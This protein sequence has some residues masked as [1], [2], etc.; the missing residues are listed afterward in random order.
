VY[1]TY[2]RTQ[3]YFT[4]QYSRNT[5]TCFGLLCGPSSGCA[6][7]Y[8]AAIQDLWNLVYCTYS[9][10]QIYFTQQYSRN[11]TTCFGPICGPSSGC[12]LIFQGQVYKMCGVFFGLLGVWGRGGER[13]GRDLV[14]IVGT[15]TWG[16]YKWIIISFLCT[17]VK[18]CFCS[19]AKGMLL[20]VTLATI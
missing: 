6:L 20:L 3:L 1:Y 14:P 4:Q 15:M 11:T 5:A 17:R 13:R 7:T 18:V 9:R 8:R 19:Y 12:D 10:T 16:Y 2:S